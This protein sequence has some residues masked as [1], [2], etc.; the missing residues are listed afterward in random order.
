VGGI[1]DLVQHGRNGLLVPP[2]DP[3]ALAAAIHQLGANPFLRAEIGRRN[4]V[5]A[6]ANLS[7]TALARRY[8]SLYHGIRQHVPARRLA[9]LHSSS[10]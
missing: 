6:E 7:W 2:R 3:L 1:P 9:E 5:D 8:L 4:R 10:W